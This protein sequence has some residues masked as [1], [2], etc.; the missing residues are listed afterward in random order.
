[1]VQ[2]EKFEEGNWKRIVEEGEEGASSAIRYILEVAQL[3]SFGA[4]PRICEIVQ[5][6][7]ETE[8]AES[9]A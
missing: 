6:S 8:R 7:C 1:M 4:P 3:L 5:G 9:I 2:E